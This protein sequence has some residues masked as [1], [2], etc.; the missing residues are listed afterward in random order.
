MLVL[1]FKLATD[2]LLLG[3]LLLEV[4]QAVGFHRADDWPGE[5]LEDDLQLRNNDISDTEDTIF[6]VATTM[7]HRVG[8]HAHIRPTELSMVV[9]R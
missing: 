9:Q 6:L 4:P 2:G 7:G 1:G 5:P 3:V 8:R